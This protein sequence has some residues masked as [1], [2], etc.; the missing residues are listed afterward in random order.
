MEQK[1]PEKRRTFLTFIG[2][3]LSGGQGGEYLPDWLGYVLAA[4]VGVGL[5]VFGAVGGGGSTPVIAGSCLLFA[6]MLVAV[7]SR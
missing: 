4:V 7:L 3:V 6:G 5:V 2:V 1:D